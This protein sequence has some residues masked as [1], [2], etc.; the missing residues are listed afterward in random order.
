M[1]P[2]P[3]AYQ[4]LGWPFGGTSEAQLP[5]STPIPAPGTVSGGHDSCQGQSLLELLTEEP[6]CY[7][8]KRMS[9]EGFCVQA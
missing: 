3:R 7:S 4:K 5:T 8:R 2:M 9:W 1:Q 6:I